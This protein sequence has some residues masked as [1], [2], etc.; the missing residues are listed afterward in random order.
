MDRWK[1]SMSDLSW[2]TWSSRV[3]FL[4]RSPLE[5]SYLDLRSPSLHS[6]CLLAFLSAQG[7]GK[8]S[9]RLSSPLLSGERGCYLEHHLGESSWRWSCSL[10]SCSWWVVERRHLH[11]SS[12]SS[13]EWIWTS[14]MD[15]SSCRHRWCSS[16]TC[17][18]L[19]QGWEWYPEKCCLTSCLSYFQ[20][21]RWEK[22]QISLAGP[23]FHLPLCK[24]L[25][26]RFRVRRA[27]SC[28]ARQY[29]Y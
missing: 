28:W 2:A 7:M 4:T 27:W 15:W 3:Y 20:K 22:H 9:Q 12:P 11:Y 6:F 8:S 21:Q 25:G 13:S 10:A 5:S 24:S 29:W 16:Q 1:S 14:K 18:N 19:G 23:H 26:R 17:T